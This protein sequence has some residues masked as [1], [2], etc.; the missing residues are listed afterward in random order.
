MHRAFQSTWE[1]DAV[2]APDY[3]LPEFWCTTRGIVSQRACYPLV[4]LETTRGCAF[5]CSFC[6]NATLNTLKR[7]HHLPILRFK[8]VENIL[9]QSRCLRNDVPELRLLHY[10]DENFL[11]RS[12]SE[13][14]EFAGSYNHAV[15]VPL[16]VMIDVR[17][18]DFHEKILQL[19]RIE[20]LRVVTLGLQTGADEFNKRVYNRPQSS[21]DTIAKC[22]FMR[23]TLGRSV[24]ITVGVMY[25]HPEATCEDILQTLN[26]ML[27]VKG[28]RF[29]LNQFVPLPATPQGKRYLRGDSVTYLSQLDARAF[30][31]SPF[32][33]F[34]LFL[35]KHLRTLHAGWLLP[36]TFQSWL[37]ELLNSRVLAPF[38]Q[39]CIRL[40]IWIGYYR[41]AQAVR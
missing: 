18:A 22:M 27:R 25:G 38:Y 9:V 36:S 23:E 29:N 26:A 14:K 5:D 1:L 11:H 21:R 7:E 32:Y 6:G 20:A 35:I 2:P 12:V 39:W 10:S 28:V 15:G 17:S 4:S 8:S 30:A 16:S 13:L 31:Q 41:F 3:R 24:Q 40:S 37:T 19:A 33:L 34:A